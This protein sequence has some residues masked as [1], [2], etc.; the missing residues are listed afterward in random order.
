MYVFTSERYII[1]ERG[2]HSHRVCR[3]ICDRDQNEI[4]GST[5]NFVLNQVIRGRFKE[6]IME[7]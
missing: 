4:K 2:S 7:E 6:A 1:N 3:I 5:R